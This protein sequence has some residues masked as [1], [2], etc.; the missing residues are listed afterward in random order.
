[1][2]VPV[3]WFVSWKTASSGWPVALL[4]GQPVRASATGFRKLIWPRGVGDDDGVA[5]TGERH[6]QPFLLDPQRR[7]GGT[8]FDSPLAPIDAAS[9]VPPRRRPRPGVGRSYCSPH[10]G[11]DESDEQ[12][13][14]EPQLIAK[15]IPMERSPKGRMKYEMTELQ[16]PPRRGVRGR[17]RHARRK[18][19][20]R[21]SR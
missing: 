8:P 3:F 21:Q 4:E 17:D 6:P 16:K 5:D 7:L 20:G 9:R 15:G 19:P 12:E 11:E 2:G 14:A 1:M 13:C 10:E 18:R